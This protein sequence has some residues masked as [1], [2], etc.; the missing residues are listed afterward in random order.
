MKR[1]L[2]L[3]MAAFMIT[4][5]LAGCS[6]TGNK[7]TADEA[8]T[9]EEQQK[10]MYRTVNKEVM[11]AYDDLENSAT[12]EDFKSAVE[13]LNAALEK[14]YA[15]AEDAIKEEDIDQA[16]H[17]ATGHFFPDG[18]ISE[19]AI[20]IKEFFLNSVKKKAQTWQGDMNF[21]YNTT[22]TTEFRYLFSKIK[23]TGEYY[24]QKT[25]V[26]IDMISSNGK[27]YTFDITKYY[28][29]SSNVTV[30]KVIGDNVYLQ[31]Y[32]T[33]DSQAEIRVNMKTG[34]I[35]EIAPGTGP[36]GWSRIPIFDNTISGPWPAEAD[37]R[38]Y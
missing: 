31:G 18:K 37:G 8:L 24:T 16:I 32:L 23:E 4:S 28:P 36:Y 38:T 22:D 7:A 33:S 19:D 26:S 15:L 35:E 20:F 2:C 12:I 3:I 34:Q 1:I 6:L 13:A 25:V 9:E 17:D 11:P 29:N 14:T 30:N 27:T 5:L 10:Q 21:Y